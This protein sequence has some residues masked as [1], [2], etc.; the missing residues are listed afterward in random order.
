MSGLRSAQWRER[1]AQQETERRRTAYQASLARWRQRDEQLRA[2]LKAATTTQPD[3]DG[4]IGWLALAPGESVYWTAS[5]V[6]LVEGAYVLRL[7]PPHYREFGRA[8]EPAAGPPIDTG[9]VV[10]TDRRVVYIGRMVR[11]WAY[12]RLIGMAHTVAGQT[13]LLVT[14]GQKVAGLAPPSP[15]VTAFRLR[16]ALALADNAGERDAF[17]VELAEQVELHRQAEP[18]PPAPATADEAPYPVRWGRYRRLLTAA[19]AALA[20]LASLLAI[21]TA[22]G[23]NDRRPDSFSAATGSPALPS[24][25]TGSPPRTAS[26]PAPPGEPMRLAVPPQEQPPPPPPTTSPPSPTPSQSPTE[27]ALDPRFSD[28]DEANENG[29][30]PY[31]RDEDPEYWWYPDRN[32]D[33]VVCRP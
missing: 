30:G 3:R 31:F 29:F 1:W 12:S 11:E 19:T 24:P 6:G 15:A 14:T 13:W 32:E 22:L 33:G 26:P 28:C 7:R 10:I 16:L 4:D 5:G 2:L 21:G 9:Q 8:E 25:P 20:V 17:V 23:G 18:P 27:D